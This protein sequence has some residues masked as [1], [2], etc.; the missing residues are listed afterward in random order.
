M[1][2]APERLDLV[3]MNSAARLSGSVQPV[4]NQEAAEACGSEIV[5]IHVADCR[6]NTAYLRL[7]AR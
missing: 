6:S 2:R 4:F 7:S 3:H 1:V 5:H